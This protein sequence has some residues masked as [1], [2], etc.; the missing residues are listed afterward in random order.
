[1]G[2]DAAPWSGIGPCLAVLCR[3]ETRFRRL[4]C[5]FSRSLGSYLIL[6]YEAAEDGSSVDPGGVQVDD[7]GDWLVGVVVWD[8]LGD[9]LM[10]AR[11]VVVERVFGQDG[12]KVCL[13]DDQ[14]LVEQ[15][16]A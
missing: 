14:D 16:A 9:A 10:R 4:A 8:L 5:G 15:F 12:A 13:V 11:R 2:L 7:G 1:M 6:A 3:T